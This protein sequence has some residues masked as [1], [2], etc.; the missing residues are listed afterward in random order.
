MITSRTKKQLLVFVFITLVGVAYV[1]AR[2]ARLDRL[3]YDSAYDV[4]AHFAQ[5]GG[6]FTGAEV[7]YRGVKVGQVSDMRLTDE[8]VNVVLEHRQGRRQDPGRHARPGRQQVGGRGAVRRPRAAA[9]TRGRSSRTAPRSRRPTPQVRSR[10][11]RVLTKA[12]P[13]STRSPQDD[14]RTRGLRV[15]RRLQGHRRRPRPDHR[16][17]E[18]VHRRRE[19]ELRR[20][21][22]ADPRL[23]HRAA[24]PVRQG[25]GDPAL[26]RDLA[27][28][29]GTVA[30]NDAALRR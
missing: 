2:Y 27:L 12:R 26:R 21:H 10:R 20:H 24:D 7:T 14:L 23:Q 4:N 13:P 19:P 18:R 5:S 3:I 15:G 16:H 8:G 30:D 22:G 6:I 28:F 17:L 1:G 9:P 11:P 25:L 29:S